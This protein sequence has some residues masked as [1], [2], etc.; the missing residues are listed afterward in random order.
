MDTLEHEK[1][2]DKFFH[3]SGTAQI[4]SEICG[5]VDKYFKRTNF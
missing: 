2:N 4:I 3:C 5:Q 1:E